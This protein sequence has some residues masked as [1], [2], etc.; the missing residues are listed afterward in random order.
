MASDLARAIEI[1]QEEAAFAEKAAHDWRSIAAFEDNL[2]MKKR[3]HKMGEVCD[4]RADR[5][6][7]VEKVLQRRRR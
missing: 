6:R 5:L 7:L 3:A 4:A 1:C 2:E